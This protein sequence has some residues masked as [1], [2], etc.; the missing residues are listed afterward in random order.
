MHVYRCGWVR[1]ALSVRVAQ[2]TPGLSVL[3][4]RG[5]TKIASSRSCCSEPAHSAYLPHSIACFPCGEH[6]SVQLAQHR[7]SGQLVIYADTRIKQPLMTNAIGR[8]R[9]NTYDDMPSHIFARSF[10]ARRRSGHTAIAHAKGLRH[11]SIYHLAIYHTSSAEYIIII[12]IIN[13]PPNAY[14]FRAI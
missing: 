12:I 2:P 8:A 13:D 14:F 7:H 5:S 4:P 6:R 1:I 9:G 11:V 10:S 3:G